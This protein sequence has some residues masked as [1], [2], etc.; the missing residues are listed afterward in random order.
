M[1]ITK[2]GPT[3]RALPA[4]LLSTACI[5][6]S[7]ALL[8]LSTGRDAAAQPEHSCY[9]PEVPVDIVEAEEKEAFMEDARAYVDCMR[10]FFDEQ[11]EL[12]REHAEAANAAKEEMEEFAALI[13]E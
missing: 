9:Q 6:A 13:N 11:A 7:V 5:G 4:R 12:S 1:T 2:R 8:A 3:A 10:E